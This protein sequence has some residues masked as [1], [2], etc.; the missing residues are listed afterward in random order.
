MDF[1]IEFDDG[2][3]EKEVDRAI[4]DGVNEVADEA[5]AETVGQV[6]ATWDRL[7]IECRGMDPAT[8]A[9]AVAEAFGSL[10]IEFLDAAE[11][12]DWTAGI[13]ADD[14]LDLNVKKD[15]RWT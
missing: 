6:R 11:L 8:A 2:D 1:G 3:F 10:G 13:L 9:D 4:R 14:D 5:A 12:A 7:R 15:I